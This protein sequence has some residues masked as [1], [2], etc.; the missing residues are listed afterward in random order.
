MWAS[1]I[2]VT[3][4]GKMVKEREQRETVRQKA[5]RMVMDTQ[6]MGTPGPD[7]TEEES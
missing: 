6:W 3:G 2:D 4:G 1:L 5:Q 7:S